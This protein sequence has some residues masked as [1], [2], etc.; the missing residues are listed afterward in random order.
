VENRS[1]GKNQVAPAA[2]RMAESV[3]RAVLC[4]PAPLFLRNVFSKSL[5]QG[6]AQQKLAAG[7][8][9]RSAGLRRRSDLA[10]LFNKTQR[11]LLS[12]PR[13]A[14]PLVDQ[15]RSEPHIR[16]QLG[17]VSQEDACGSRLEA[18][19]QSAHFLDG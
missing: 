13:P 8:S 7:C 15:S 14:G 17:L 1:D 5:W 16:L 10:S 4:L 11:R 3:E 9:I 6:D 18:A 19:C 12:R 2:E